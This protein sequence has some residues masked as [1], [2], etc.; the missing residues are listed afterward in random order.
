[1]SI[2]NSVATLD[3][4][5]WGSGPWAN[6]VDWGG[7]GDVLTGTVNVWEDPAFVAPDAGNYHIG[8]GSAAIDRGV[9]AGV[10]DDVDGNSRPFDGDDD[11]VGEFDIGADEA[12]CQRVYLPLVLK[13]P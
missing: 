6:D 4:T 7:D 13:S 12:V 5:L 9:D 11:G 2:Q 1:M 8:P 3:A 10:S